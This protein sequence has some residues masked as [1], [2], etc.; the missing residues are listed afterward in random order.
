MQH[1]LCMCLK[2]FL[3]IH[4][5]HNY[6]YM[7]LHALRVTSHIWTVNINVEYVLCVWFVRMWYTK[8]NGGVIH[9]C[10][11]YVSLTREIAGFECGRSRVQSPVKDRVILKTL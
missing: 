11:G 2:L 4:T 7:L 8:V 3:T 1:H 6:V 10:R 9:V 5:M